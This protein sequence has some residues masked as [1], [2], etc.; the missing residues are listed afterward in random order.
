[1]DELANITTTRDGKEEMLRCEEIFKQICWLEERF[2]PD[3]DGM[4]EEDDTG[5]L[6]NGLSNGIGSGIGLGNNLGGSMNGSMS[7]VMTANM[8]GGQTNSSQMPIDLTR[9]N[10]TGATADDD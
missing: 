4:G 9:S 7:G 10:A 5:R 8:A 3:V 1:M 2:W 6:G